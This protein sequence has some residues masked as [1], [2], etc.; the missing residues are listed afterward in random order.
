VGVPW[1]LATPE[2]EEAFRRDW[3]LGLTLREL[4]A[5]H[6]FR[7]VNGASRAA[8]RLGLPRRAGGPPPESELALAGGRWVS[9]GRVMRWVDEGAA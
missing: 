3:A 7:N 8:R 2:Q 1:V 5:L 4:A 6:G 9:D